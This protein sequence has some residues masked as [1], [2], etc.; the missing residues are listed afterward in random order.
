MGFMNYERPS[1]LVSSAS[2]QMLDSRYAH[3]PDPRSY[4]NVTRPYSAPPAADG[5]PPSR[6]ATRDDSGPHGNAPSRHEPNPRSYT[7]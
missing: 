2:D 1:A 6:Y 3:Q 4:A 5:G 7:F